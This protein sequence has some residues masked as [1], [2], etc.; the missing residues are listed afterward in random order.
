MSATVSGSSRRSKVKAKGPV[1][2]GG[3]GKL[4]IWQ[5][6]GRA[7]EQNIIASVLGSVIQSCGAPTKRAAMNA[8]LFSAG[9]TTTQVCPTPGRGGQMVDQLRTWDSCASGII[10]GGDAERAQKRFEDWM[11]P[12]PD[13]EHPAQLAI[14]RVVAAQFVDQLLTES[15]GEPL[16]WPQVARQV[17]DL[18]ETP[19]QDDFEQGYWVD[20][21]QAV[22]PG[23]VSSDLE[24]LQRELPEDIRSGLNWSPDR[25]FFFL[26]SILSP[27]PMSAPPADVSDHDLDPAGEDDAGQ[28]L[29]LESCVSTLLEM[30]DKEAAALVHARNSVVAAWLWRKYATDTRLALNEIHIAPCCG[31]IPVE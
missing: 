22:P 26:V 13:A 18:V 20:I 17:T 5:S 30:R 9:Y 6:G 25:Q 27:L 24:A 14:K 2:A 4:T 28:Q 31:L 11:T 23:K 1:A 8:Y 15:G 3:V 19:A 10:Y 21:I 7:Q 29:E 16:D 12:A